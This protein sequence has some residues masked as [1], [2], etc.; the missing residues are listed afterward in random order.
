MCKTIGPI[1]STV[2]NKNKKRITIRKL[3]TETN[4][5]QPQIKIPMTFFPEIEK[6]SLVGDIA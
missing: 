2:K 4:S 1:P 5:V 6:K 3:Y